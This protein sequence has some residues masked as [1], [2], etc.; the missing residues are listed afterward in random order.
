MLER[1]AN[2]SA[3]QKIVSSF[4]RVFCA[5]DTPNKVSSAY[6]WVHLKANYAGCVRFEKACKIIAFNLYE[7]FFS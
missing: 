6:T 7:V 2:W 4:L 3:L 5:K 1:F